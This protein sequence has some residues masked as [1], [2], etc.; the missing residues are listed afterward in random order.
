MGYPLGAKY[1]KNA[2]YNE[3][4]KT[5][6]VCVSVTYHKDIEV[7]V[8]GAYDESTLNYLAREEVYNMHKFMDDDG[9]TED[10]FEAIED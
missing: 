8:E 3:K 1:D 7:E 2:P 5:V 9:W 10:E 6:S 4:T